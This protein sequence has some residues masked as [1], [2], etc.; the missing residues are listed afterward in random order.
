MQK[1]TLIRLNWNNVC[2]AVVRQET[3]CHQVIHEYVKGF[4]TDRFCEEL[5]SGIIDC[6][7]EWYEQIR[8]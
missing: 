5:K 2:I 4:Q 3:N 6:L 7:V 1:G 8:N